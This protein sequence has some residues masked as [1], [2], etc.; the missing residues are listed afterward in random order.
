M[1]ASSTSLAEARA[2]R[3]MMLRHPPGHVQRTMAYF[4]SLG[5]YDRQLNRMREAYAARRAATARALARHG[6]DAGA[7]VAPGGSSFWL[8]T[9]RGLDSDALALALRPEG[10]LIEPLR[11]IRHLLDEGDHVIDV[12]APFAAGLFRH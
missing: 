1:A 5:H 6:L 8:P 7:A 3:G 11:I 4:L 10:V 9:P 12:E 2:L